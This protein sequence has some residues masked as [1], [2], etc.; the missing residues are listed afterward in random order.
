M[1]CENL[2]RDK[3]SL[4]G[5]RLHR[6]VDEAE[7]VGCLSAE[8][9]ADARFIATMRN[10]IVH[11]YGCRELLDASAFVRRSDKL[12]CELS[13]SHVEYLS[14]EAHALPLSIK[15]QLQF[16]VDLSKHIE[17]ILINR[18]N[19]MPDEG[20]IRIRDNAR[21][22]TDEQLCED[23]GYIA[24]VRNQIIHDNTPLN[25][26]EFARFKDFSQALSVKMQEVQLDDLWYRYEEHLP[27]PEGFQTTQKRRPQPAM[28][29]ETDPQSF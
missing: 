17:Q 21:L 29:L 9:I 5:T 25:D 3:Y 15:S 6:L 22:L 18:F 26:I 16:V 2:L 19:S 27:R 23:I 12:L 11:E 14:G 4:V 20:L 1:A 8:V 24:A 7:S 13:G 10:K 28:D